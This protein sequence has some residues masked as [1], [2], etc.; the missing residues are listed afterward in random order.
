MLTSR[1]RHARHWLSSFLRE[2]TGGMFWRNMAIAA[3]CWFLAWVG[4]SAHDEIRQ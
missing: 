3:L 2:P 1:R 4:T